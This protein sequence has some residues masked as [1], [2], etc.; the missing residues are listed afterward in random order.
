M[1]M[2]LETHLAHQIRCPLFKFISIIIFYMVPSRIGIVDYYHINPWYHQILLNIIIF[3]FVIRIRIEII[4]F[5]FTPDIN[6]LWSI[7]NIT[8]TV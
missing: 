8:N 6:A 4:I 7:K 1:K 5:I 2:I 3:F